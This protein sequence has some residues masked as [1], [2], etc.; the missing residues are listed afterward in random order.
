MQRRRGKSREG[1][2]RGRDVRDEEKSQELSE[3]ERDVE[4]G[5]LLTAGL[6]RQL[7]VR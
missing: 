4:R 5:S 1:G 2:C 3:K 6:D 7:R